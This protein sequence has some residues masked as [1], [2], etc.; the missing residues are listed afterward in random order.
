MFGGVTVKASE[1]SEFT[2]HK[3]HCDWIVCRAQ[4]LKALLS[5]ESEQMVAANKMRALG[6]VST[7]VDSLSELK[8]YIESVGGR[9]V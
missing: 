7:M 5:Y 3:A 8:L 4:E 6:C 2:I 9:A 1:I